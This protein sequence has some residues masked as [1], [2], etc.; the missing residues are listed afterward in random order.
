MGVRCGMGPRLSS[1]NARWGWR[2][3]TGSAHSALTTSLARYGLIIRDA[4]ASEGRIS[5]L[6]TQYADVATRCILRV[7][8][9]AR[10]EP[11]RNLSVRNL[12]DQQCAFLA[13]RAPRA[14]GSFEAR[15]ASSLEAGFSNRVVSGL[16]T[17]HVG[18]KGPS[19]F[20]ANK[21]A[22]RGI[23]CRALAI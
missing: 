18:L 1:R 16:I 2:L 3:L 20:D 22:T 14:P 11:V 17:Q 7:S 12:S 15:S 6:G 13:R 8:R 21:L 19:E 9:T 10:L 23:I 4:C 5:R